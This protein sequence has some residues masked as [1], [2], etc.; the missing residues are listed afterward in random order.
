VIK[1]KTEGK[2]GRV[3]EM[4]RKKNREQEVKGR[5]MEGKTKEGRLR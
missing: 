5:A 4:E 2:Y 3:R 1:G